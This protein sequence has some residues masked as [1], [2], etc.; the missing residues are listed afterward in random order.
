[1]PKLDCEICLPDIKSFYDL[2]AQI[3][4]LNLK[5]LNLAMLSPHGGRSFGQG[6]IIILRDDV[7]AL[8]VIV[9]RFVADFFAAF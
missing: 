3:V 9:V 4:D 8:K 7:K 6:R 5:L 2:S 1:M